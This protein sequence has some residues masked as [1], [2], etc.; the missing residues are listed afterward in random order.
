MFSYIS[1]LKIAFHHRKFKANKSQWADHHRL[2]SNHASTIRNDEYTALHRRMRD[3]L[4]L[5]D[6]VLE[7]LL[8]QRTYLV[9]MAVESYRNGC[10]GPMKS[11]A[12][13]DHSELGNRVR[14]PAGTSRWRDG[15]F[16]FLLHDGKLTAVHKHD[17][18]MGATRKPVTC[19]VLNPVS[20]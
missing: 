12:V 8:P 10:L 15:T 3:V 5:R 18:L 7:M 19:Y 6:T 20:P 17:N 13:Y 2:K 14:I 4:Y 9:E 11:V 16:Y 1:R